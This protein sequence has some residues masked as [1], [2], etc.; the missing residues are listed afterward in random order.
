MGGG[1]IAAS[2]LVAVL[3]NRSAHKEAAPVEAPRAARATFA[4]ILANAASAGVPAALTGL[5]LTMRTPRTSP[6]QAL[7][8]YVRVSPRTSRPCRPSSPKYSHCCCALL[9]AACARSPQE[10]VLSGPTMGTTYTVKVAAPP[11]SLDAARG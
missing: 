6:L 5:P 8:R 11:A 7:T 3:L 9:A 2:F 1:L 4:K 10:L